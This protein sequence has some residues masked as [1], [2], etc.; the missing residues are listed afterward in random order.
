MNINP[1][2]SLPLSLLQPANN[3]VTA[4]SNV[5]SIN[6]TPSDSPDIS[7]AARFLSMLQQIQ[8][9]DPTLFKQI[10][11]Q[12]ATRL[13][14]EAKN[15][16]SQGN[17]S[18]ANQLNQL[19]TEFQNAANTGQLPSAQSLQQ[20][21]LGGHHHGHH[22]HHGSGQASQVDPLAAQTTT[23]SQSLLTSIFNSSTNGANST[24]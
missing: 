14:T 22:G 15:A 8:Q 9:Q 4:N 3:T 13:E 11:S 19:A 20:A 16:S 23:D 2:S 17:S 18:Q 1:V 5:T 6:G 12:I 21:G 24:T 7:P 10:T